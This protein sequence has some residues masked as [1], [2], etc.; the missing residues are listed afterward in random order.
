MKNNTSNPRYLAVKTLERVS[1]GAYSNL[2]INNVIDSTNMNE[3]DVRLF[4]TIVYGVIQ[5]RLTFEYYIQKMVKHPDKLKPWVKE[6]LY[7]AIYQM[8]YLDKVPNRAIFDESIEIDKARGHDGIRRLVTGIL[9]K[10]N[11]D[12]LPSLDDIKDKTEYLS[13]KFSVPVWIIEQLNNQL[14]KEKTEKILESINEP[15]NQSLRVN[16]K[17]TNP[18]SLTKMLEEK[19]F[20]VES[21]KVAANALVVSNGNA[22]HTDLFKDGLFTIQDESAMLPVQSMQIASDDYILDACAAPGGKTTQI[23]EYLTTG[24]VEALDLHENKLNLIKK[25]AERMGVA[26]QIEV[27][28]CDSRKLDKL[29]N[30]ETFD[31]ILVD[32]PCTGMGLIRRKPE[33]R[34]DK[35]I[36]DVESLSRI[37]SQILDA[38]APKL[39]V[40]GQLVFST[41]SIINQENSANVTKFLNEHHNFAPI[42]VE[43]KMNLKPDRP[44]DYLKIFPDDYGS[45]G[46]F[47]SGFKKVK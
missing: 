42:R 21:S 31:K 6:L 23:A 13:I 39:K 19:G 10:I 43:T 18:S 38:V 8:V 1:N 32:A 29:F 11:R 15:A 45:D 40:G 37:Q 9:H 41:C 26:N 12:G 14:G 44:E 2:Q 22:A 47:I 3:K 16:I 35:S 30:D 34:Y 46:F 17:S 5:H 4:T 20:E 24:K 25:N 33:I 27:H 28:A 7:T 36:R